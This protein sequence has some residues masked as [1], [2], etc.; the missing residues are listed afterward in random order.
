MV[1]SSLYDNFTIVLTDCWIKIEVTKGTK[2]LLKKTKSVKVPQREV[3]LDNTFV[4]N[5]V[6]D[7]S[8]L[9]LQCSLVTTVTA[10]LMKRTKLLGKVT[11]GSHEHGQALRHWTEMVDTPDTQIA[12]WHNLT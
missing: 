6:N 7:A 10:S 3:M 8:C 5:D 11:L 1:S 2:P 4:C 12:E 9:T